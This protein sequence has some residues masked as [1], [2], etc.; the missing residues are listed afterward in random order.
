VKDKW[1]KKAAELGVHRPEGVDPFDWGHYC[2]WIQSPEYKDIETDWGRY[3]DEDLSYAVRS[4]DW[5]YYY[6]YWL[7]RNVGRG[8]PAEYHE[9]FLEIATKIKL[10]LLK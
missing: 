4:Q 5:G 10:G 9:K 6:S 2:S 1:V 8:L 7:L 3:A